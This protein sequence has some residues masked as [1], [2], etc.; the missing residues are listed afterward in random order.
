MTN[1]K[2][3][4]LYD[5]RTNADLGSA[6]EEQVKASDENARV[7]NGNGFIVIDAAG[8]PVPNAK[9]PM[10]RFGERVVFTW[11]REWWKEMGA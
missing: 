8:K 2:G 10:L 7:D 6:T 9:A 5:A 4:H 3:H 1:S 11:K